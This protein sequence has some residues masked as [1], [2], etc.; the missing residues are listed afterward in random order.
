VR[1]G[2]GL[3]RAS[4]VPYPRPLLPF[5]LPCARPDVARRA[6]SMDVRSVL[7]IELVGGTADGATVPAVQRTEVVAENRSELLELPVRKLRE[8]VECQPHNGLAARRGQ[9]AC[10]TLFFGSP[11][12]IS[13]EMNR[14]V[15]PITYG[16]P[17]TAF[18]SD[19]SAN[20]ACSSMTP[21]CPLTVCSECVEVELRQVVQHAIQSERAPG[22]VP[23]TRDG[24]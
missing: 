2:V 23:Q 3:H 13:A 16:I 9:R 4:A 20:T 11:F 8:V 1:T 10:S 17:T 12:A 15:L 6:K 19:G 18:L 5:D 14:F 24:W 7:P 22:F 21:R